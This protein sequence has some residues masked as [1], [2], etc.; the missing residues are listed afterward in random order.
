MKKWTVI[1]VAVFAALSFLAAG[2]RPV[3][4]S[5]P[6][7]LAFGGYHPVSLLQKGELVK[8]TAYLYHN[9][10][11][12][13]WRFVSQGN[14]DVF[15][16]NPQKYA[17]VFGGYCAVCVATASSDAENPIPTVADPSAYFVYKEKI[18]VFHNEGLRRQFSQTPDKFI[19]AATRHWQRWLRQGKIETVE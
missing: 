17:P 13:E 15:K 8:G 10:M 14:R 11:G 18:Y 2:F 6:E 9:W 3:A 16:K 5:G 4:V 7:R 19:E 12:A 1:Q